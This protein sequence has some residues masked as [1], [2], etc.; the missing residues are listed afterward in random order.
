M[1]KNLNII[2]LKE[3]EA[4]TVLFKYISVLY[5]DRN[6]NLWV[7]TASGIALLDK[8]KTLV[9]VYSHTNTAGSLC[10]NN[11][12]SIAQDSEGRI[13][14]GTRSGLNLFDEKAKTFKL[15]TVSDGL[16]DNSI[17]NVLADKN[18][19]LWISTPKGVCNVVLKNIKI[20]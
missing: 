1:P 12:I 18:N 15:F 4:N 9:G 3:N 2:N 11:V 8:N 17:S 19:T 16:P 20:I 10:D 7:G 5:Q 13:W 14:V 6:E